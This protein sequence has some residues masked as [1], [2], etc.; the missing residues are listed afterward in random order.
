MSYRSSAVLRY[1]PSLSAFVHG[2]L[3]P[4]LHSSNGGPLQCTCTWFAAA[5]NYR[6]GRA[7]V[8]VGH[9]LDALL[10]GA[11][12]SDFLQVE[13]GSRATGSTSV[14]TRMLECSGWGGVMWVVVLY[15]T[16]FAG[17]GDTGWGG[18]GVERAVA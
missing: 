15:C 3:P 16:F 11:A 4:C 6:W 12:A 7:E 10:A 8:S 17:G 9:A 18:R 14:M 1:W 13:M 2:C 5:S